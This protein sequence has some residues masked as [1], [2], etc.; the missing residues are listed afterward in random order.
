MEICFPTENFTYSCC[1]SGFS[2]GGNSKICIS[3]GLRKLLNFVAR[4]D[5]YFGV[6]LSRCGHMVCHISARVHN[7]L[8][9]LNSFFTTFSRSMVPGRGVLP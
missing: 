1:G 9:L 2:L 7:G 8:C 3:N 6:G 4:I 5:C